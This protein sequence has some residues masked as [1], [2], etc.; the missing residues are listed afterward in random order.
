MRASHAKTLRAA[1]ACLAALLLGACAPTRWERNGLALDYA[2]N[3]WKDCRSQSIA[4]ANRWMFEPFPRTFIGRD[5]RGRPFSFYRDSPY[6]SRFMLE[7][8][9]LDYCLRARGFQRMPVK[10]AD[11]AGTAQTPA[12]QPAPEIRE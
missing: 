7:Q 11:A 10:P 6:Q 5:A 4:S 12:P 1:A 9:F 2:G 3:D 8:D